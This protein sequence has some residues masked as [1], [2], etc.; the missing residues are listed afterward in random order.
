[1]SNKACRSGKAQTVGR[2]PDFF[3]SPPSQI[4]PHFVIP[5]YAIALTTGFV[6]L[7]A[8]INIGS[9][10][11]FNAIVSLVLAGF[12]SSYLIAIIFL[13]RRRLLGEHIPFG[14]WRLGRFGLPINIFAVCYLLLSLFFSFFPPKV[15]VTAETMNWS[16]LVYATVVLSGIAYYA[17]RGR[18]NYK[19]PIMDRQFTH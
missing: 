17:L 2:E 19:G 9:T 5:L 6:A 1:V 7:L 18:H 3:F 12:F 16:A 13:I 11:A 8:L 14:P 10:T 15:P 4:N